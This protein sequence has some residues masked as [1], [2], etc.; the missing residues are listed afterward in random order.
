M[1]QLLKLS[2]YVSRYEI[3]IYRYPARYV[4]LKKERWQRLKQDWENRKKGYNDLP[5]WNDYEKKDSSII[6]KSL[7]LFRRKKK[8]IKEEVDLPSEQQLRHHTM[9]ELKE[10]FRKELFEFQVNW[11]S[12]TVSKV[13]YVKK[14]YYFDT[15]LNFL[16][17]E[18]PDT[19]FVF[20]EPSFILKKAPVDLEVIVLT[21]SEVWLIHPLRG[22]SHTIFQPESDRFWVRKQDGRNERILHPFISL[23]RMKTVVEGILSEKGMSLPIRTAVVAKDSFIDM[24]AAGK[25]I[26]IIDKRSFDTFKQSIL[27]NKSPIKHV[28]LKAADILLSQ[29]LTK[30]EHRLSEGEQ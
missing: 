24:P 9:E 27:K 11:A 3:D 7:R 26:K 29:S 19:Y 4:R 10:T 20:Y 17:N 28:Q 30:S 2:D 6:I 15:L 5:F 8:D 18:L 14:S 16:L 1:G 12:S 21:P 13:S 22:N 23:R 25:N